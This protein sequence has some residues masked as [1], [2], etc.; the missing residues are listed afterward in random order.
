MLH[1]DGPEGDVDMSGTFVNVMRRQD[2]G[3]WLCLLD[4][5]GSNPVL[6]GRLRERAA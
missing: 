1:G 6:P 2:D 4:Y 5:P 3:K